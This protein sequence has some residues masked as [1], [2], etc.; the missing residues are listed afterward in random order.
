MKQLIK[1]LPEPCW[2]LRL[3]E[4]LTRQKRDLKKALREQV[5]MEV[6]AFLVR[7]RWEMSFFSEGKA[8]GSEGKDAPT[9]SDHQ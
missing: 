2:P 3:A 7:R 8:E 5:H 6:C 1:D 4:V 9:A